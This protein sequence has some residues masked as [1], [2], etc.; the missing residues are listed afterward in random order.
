MAELTTI[1]VGRQAYAETLALQHELLAEVQGSEAELARLILVEHDPPV[2]TMGRARGQENIVATPQQLAG[3]GVEIHQTTRGGDVTYHGP[4]QLVGYPIVRVDLHGRDVHNY[5]RDL[6]EALIRLLAR[7]GIDGGRR[8]GLTGIWVGD[9]KIAAI[10]VA[11]SRW[12]SYHGFALNVAP[13]LSHFGLIVPCGITDKG[14]TSMAAV[15]GRD[16]DV[17]EVKAPLVECV[18]DVFGFE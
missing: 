7:F 4:G 8:E 18:V 12:V 1:D 13:N 14:V 16:V 17:A 9:E 11:F 5:L 6:E 3:E 10:G 15:L 2:I